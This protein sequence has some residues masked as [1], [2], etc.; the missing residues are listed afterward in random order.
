MGRIPNSMKV[1]IFA[2]DP[3]GNVLHIWPDPDPVKIEPCGMIHFDLHY[4]SDKEADVALIRFQVGT[5]VISTAR[6]EPWQ[7]VKAGW[8][9]HVSQDLLFH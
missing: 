6:V 5:E 7:H 9:V 1:A 8:D 2:Y 3:D 4:T